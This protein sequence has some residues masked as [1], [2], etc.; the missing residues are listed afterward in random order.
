MKCMR[1]TAG[2]PWTVYKPNPK[3]AKQL[4]TTPVLARIQEY[5][6]NWLQH[7]NIMTLNRLPRIIKIIDQQGEET[8][9]DN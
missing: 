5:R 1:K 6:R 2:C 8:R 9:G 4:N 7:K 3:I